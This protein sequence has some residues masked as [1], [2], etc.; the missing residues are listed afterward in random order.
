MTNPNLEKGHHCHYR[1]YLKN[2]PMCLGFLSVPRR[3]NSAELHCTR[4]I[5]NCANL[6][7][8][9][10]EVLT[11]SGER[12]LQGCISSP[13]GQSGCH[14]QK[15]WQELHTSLSRTMP[16]CSPERSDAWTLGC[17]GF[18]RAPTPSWTCLGFPEKKPQIL[19]SAWIGATTSKKKKKYRGGKLLRNKPAI[20]ELCSKGRPDTGFVWCIWQGCRM[21]HR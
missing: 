20:S 18:P 1:V 17:Q 4:L 7:L 14:S 19:I 21:I 11:K 5:G 6:P 10:G 16:C 2:K 9:Y 13:G 15:R 12:S 3:D 8:D